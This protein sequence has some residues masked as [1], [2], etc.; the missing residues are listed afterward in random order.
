MADTTNPALQTVKPQAA[1]AAFLVTNLPSGEPSLCFEDE[2]GDYGNEQFTP[3]FEPLYLAAPA[4]AI[5]M[6]ARRCRWQAR[7]KWNR[8]GA[9]FWSGGK[10][11]M[12]N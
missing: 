1:P 12:P 5:S 4:Q 6:R 7:W 9:R 11:V 10:P 2:R 3:V 8:G